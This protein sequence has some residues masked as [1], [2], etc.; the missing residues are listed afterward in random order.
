MNFLNRL[1]GKGCSHKFSWPR[2]YTD[3][4][5]YQTCS[6]CGISYEY[7][8]NTMQQTGRVKSVVVQGSELTPPL[9][10]GISAGRVS[11]RFSPS[12]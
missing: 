2:L 6:R 8:W 1:L 11:S 3:G 4:L 10:D 9:S 7:D 12:R 5:H